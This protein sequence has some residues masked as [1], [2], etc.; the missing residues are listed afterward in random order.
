[1]GMDLTRISIFRANKMFINGNTN[2]IV[3]DFAS[4]GAF[5]LFEHDEEKTFSVLEQMIISAMVE[6]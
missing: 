2:V 4:R 1:M 6:G 5:Q 3:I